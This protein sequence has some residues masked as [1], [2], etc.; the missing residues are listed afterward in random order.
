MSV[1]TIGVGAKTLSELVKR[2]SLLQTPLVTIAPQRHLAASQVGIRRDETRHSAH[3]R[4][5]RSIG[6]IISLEINLL[7][8]DKSVLFD[9]T[10]D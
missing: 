2:G 6:S 9:P 4:K 7:D 10:R 5:V 3:T 8:F 1:K